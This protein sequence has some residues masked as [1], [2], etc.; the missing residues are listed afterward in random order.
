MIT[1]S[2]IEEQRTDGSREIKH[3]INKTT[4]NQADAVLHRESGAAYIKYAPNGNMVMEVWYFEGHIH[5]IGGPAVIEH[6]SDGGL[7]QKAWYVDGE[8]HRTDGPATIKYMP[9]GSVEYE[10]YA[11]RGKRI[12]KE[13]LYDKEF[14]IKRLCF[15]APGHCR[16]CGWTY[17][18]YFCCVEDQE[19]SGIRLI[20]ARC[21]R[22]SLL[23]PVSTI[24]D[25]TQ[26]IGVGAEIS[27]KISTKLAD[28]G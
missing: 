21:G 2:K 8:T 15:T 14:N 9:D 11:I 3:T 7:I 16:W 4:N 20:C 25:D 10:I 24:T 5:R 13:G 1:I 18:F 26:G 17:G 28:G 22:P 19:L 6:S 12:S 27:I 23:Q